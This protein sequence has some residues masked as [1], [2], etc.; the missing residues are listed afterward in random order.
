MSFTYDLYA[1]S[2]EK[3]DSRVTDPVDGEYRGSQWLENTGIQGTA[4][5]NTRGGL[6]IANDWGIQ[7]AIRRQSDSYWYDIGIPGFKDTANDPY[8]NAVNAANMTETSATDWG[9]TLTADWVRTLS[10][11]EFGDGV[12]Y[13][14]ISICRDITESAYGGP[15]YELVYETSTFIMD[16]GEPSSAILAPADD[17]YNEMD[18]VSG[19]ADDSLS[20]VKE[21]GGVSIRIKFTEGTTT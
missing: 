15:N 2:P 17:F 16:K 21:I 8:W 7:Y 9:E 3:P 13:D 12:S 5:D 1:A 11:T 18:L 10:A 4:S 14:V 19:T 20:K 6:D